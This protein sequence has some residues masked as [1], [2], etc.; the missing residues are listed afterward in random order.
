MPTKKKEEVTVGEAAHHLKV[1]RQAIHNA[2]RKKHLKA[3]RKKVVKTE[4]LISVAALEAYE[5]S[6]LHQAVGKKNK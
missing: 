6:A 5:V 3:R 4:W 1:S 2:I